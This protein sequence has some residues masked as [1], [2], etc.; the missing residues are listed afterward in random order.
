MTVGSLHKHPRP[1]RL[2]LPANG[3]PPT[4]QSLAGTT[5]VTFSFTTGP[6][7]KLLLPGCACDRPLLTFCILQ[8]RNS[9]S[10]YPSTSTLTDDF[11]VTKEKHGNESLTSVESQDRQAKD[12]ELSTD[13]PNG[14]GTDCDEAKKDE[15]GIEEHGSTEAPTDLHDDAIQE[16]TVPD[17]PDGEVCKPK[18]QD[19]PVA[20]KETAERR[21]SSNYTYQDSGRI[22]SRQKFAWSERQLTSTRRE[23]CHNN[24]LNFDQGMKIRVLTWNVGYLEEQNAGLRTRNRC[25]ADL[26][27]N[28]NQQTKIINALLDR[29]ETE[30][31][32][33]HLRL[34]GQEGAFKISVERA[35]NNELV[36][37]QQTDT[38]RRRL[39]DEQKHS[40]TKDLAS[41]KDLRESQKR[42][43]ELET[44]ARDEDTAFKKRL[45]ERDLRVEDLEARLK[46]SEQA[47]IAAEAK[48]LRLREQVKTMEQQAQDRN[49]EHSVQLNDYSAKSCVDTSKTHLVAMQEKIDAVVK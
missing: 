38:Y 16:G 14:D 48:T 28:S 44:S 17:Q 10:P 47:T 6:K 25:I 13:G 18:D 40:R 34:H 30:R 12:A 49:S 21:A 37:R 24:V 43:T 1:R 5:T 46:A 26:L 27:V 3:A 4:T 22:V 29:T 45:E 32:I 8:H 36:S 19:L 2:S 41:Q 33:S 7:R 11:L 39:E 42:V 23:L 35:R 9:S 31:V 20:T 15:S